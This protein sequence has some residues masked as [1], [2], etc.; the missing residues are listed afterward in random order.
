MRIGVCTSF[1]NAG[2][3]AGSAEFI[4]EI[5]QRV[6]VGEAD[7]AAFAAATQGA[8][9]CPLPITAANCYIPGHLKTTGPELD[10]DR[11]LAYSRTVLARAQELGITIIVFGSGGS[12][13]L[14]EGVSV[15]EAVEQFSSVAKAM[16]PIAAEHGVTIVIEPLNSGDCN[17]INSLQ[18]GAEIVERAGHP[19]VL[20]LADFYHMLRDGESA[21]EI[22]RFGSLL[23]HV[24]IAEGANR[25]APGV[26]GE[27]F[28]PYLEALKAVDYPG[29]ISI[30]CSWGDDFAAEAPAAISALRQQM[31]DVGL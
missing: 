6:L 9:E 27:D 5:I 25:T 20:L 18:D 2:A 8:A 29:D 31:T 11:L 19:N 1:E 28:R 16:G 15:A 3:I 7:D 10:L 23:R 21:D 17:F 4:E 14:Q 24:H 13:A 22:R 30:E 12:R 26:A